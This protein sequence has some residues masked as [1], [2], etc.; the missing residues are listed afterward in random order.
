MI[1]ITKA[2]FFLTWKKVDHTQT[3]CDVHRACSTHHIHPPGHRLSP[4][5]PDDTWA[6]NSEGHSASAG[7]Q[8]GLCDRLG[9]RVGIGPFPKQPCASQ[10]VFLKLALRQTLRPHYLSSLMYR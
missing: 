6:H 4:R 7:D 8:H 9:E 1:T 5:R 10:L 2:K 3:S